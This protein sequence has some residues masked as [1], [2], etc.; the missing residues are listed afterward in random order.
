MNEHKHYPVNGCG[1]VRMAKILKLCLS[2]IF[3]RLPLIDWE[4]ET[5]RC[6]QCD[7]MIR[8]PKSMKIR[9]Q[10][11]PL[12]YPLIVVPCVYGLEVAEHLVKH[13]N[14]PVFVAGII[15][16][17]WIMLCGLLMALL[18]DSIVLAFGKWSAVEIGEQ[19]LEDV[20]KKLRKEVELYQEKYPEKLIRFIGMVFGSIT[21]ITVLH[22]IIWP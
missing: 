3:S 7:K 19:S 11:Y 14:L 1:L 17:L 2:S 13:S 4:T 6:A 10:F 20:K 22:T 21:I 8:I 12:S 5:A 9:R 18:F 15:F 16:T